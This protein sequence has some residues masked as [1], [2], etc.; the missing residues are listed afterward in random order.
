[1]R[2]DTAS[3]IDLSSEL[4]GWV[5]RGFITVEQ[6]ARIR[7]DLQDRH[8]PVSTLEVRTSMTQPPV[9]AEPSTRGASL[10]TEA[11]GYLGGIVILVASGLV[12]GR[13]WEQLSDAAR[14]VGAFAV[15]ALLVAAGWLVPQRLG[16]PAE[17]LRSVL[18][19]AS[20]AAMAASLAL[21]A[22]LAFGWE[23]E[24]VAILAA[25]GTAV[26]AAVLWFFHR[27]LLQHA[28]VL[29]AITV[30]AAT[31]TAM[32]NVPDPLPGLAVWGVGLTWALLAWG[33]ILQPRGIG[34][35]LGSAVVVFGSM[36]LMGERWGT[37]VG[38]ATVVALVGVAVAMRNLPLLGIASLGTLV[39]LP[40]AVTT[41]FPGM[42][43]AA[44]ALLFVGVLLVGAA[45][46]TARRRRPEQTSLPEGRDLSVGP[47]RVAMALA[48]LVAVGTASAILLV[49]AL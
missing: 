48:V 6:A 31:A 22:T 34:V 30:T 14:I 28:T 38:L 36:T 32:L 15:T 49:A 20:S 8:A 13:L 47:P 39:V 33:G 23:D 4:D 40:A 19:A 43:S 46:L 17:R 26:F 45:I 25:L 3:T 41:F 24:G 44:I 9:V 2:T 18:W 12:V 16:P 27:H 35:L 21:L 1:M 37:V 5:D 10:V 7:A 11:L 42:L 29:L